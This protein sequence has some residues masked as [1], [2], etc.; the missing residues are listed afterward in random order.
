VS[1]YGGCIVCGVVLGKDDK[2]RCRDCVADAYMEAT[3]AKATFVRLTNDG[4]VDA[5][6][7]AAKVGELMAA[8]DDGAVLRDDPNEI[9]AKVAAVNDARADLP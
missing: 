5:S 9:W 8:I 1:T 6:D 3:G 7:W 4:P 2:L